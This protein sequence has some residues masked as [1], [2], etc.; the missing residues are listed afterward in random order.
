[1]GGID[2]RSPG[3]ASLFTQTRL[4]IL[5]F[6]SVLLI[7]L[8]LPTSDYYWDGISFAQ[9]IEDSRSLSPDLLHP[10]HLIYTPVGYLIHTGLAQ[11]GF[12]LR[13]LDVLRMI[14]SLLS[15]LSSWVLFYIL[16]A[17]TRS[18]YLS[19]SLAVIFSF[20]GYWWKFS[21]DANAYVPSVFFLLVT[22]YL[23]LPDRRVRPFLIALLHVTAIL[24]HQLAVFFYPAVLAALWQQSS[25]TPSKGRLLNLARYSLTAFL[26]TSL[27][28]YGGF[29][30]RSGTAN[31][32]SFVGW[33][34]SYSP[35]VS[36]SSDVF[37]NA[38]YSLRGHHRLFFKLRIRIFREIADPLAYLAAFVLLIAGVVFFYKL[39]VHR[40]QLKS[41]LITAFNRKWW[42]DPPL[43]AVVL[44][45]GSYLIFLFFWLPQNTFYRMLYLPAIVLLLGVLL[46][47]QQ[48]KRTYTQLYLPRLSFSGTWPFRPCPTPTPG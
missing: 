47:D 16:L 46:S 35:E 28:Y 14:N 29:L 38:A 39:V 25:Q 37:R 20:S 23:L 1:M 3:V 26:A 30:L 10:N 4:S 12:Q 7:Y 13:A 22:F 17:L 27:I 41:I 32:V 19:F 42:A 18:R 2:I 48:R 33:M 44:W 45:L 31:L 24:F 6:L 34:T 9:N 43:P 21:T 36:F 5:L 8:A 40:R 11:F 15:A